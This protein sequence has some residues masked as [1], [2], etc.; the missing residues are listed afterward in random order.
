MEL[1]ELIKNSGDF[2]L[3]EIAEKL[4]S[5]NIKCLSC[6]KEFHQED[7]RC[8]QHRHGIFVKGYDDQYDNPQKQWVYFTCSFCMHDSK[9]NQLVTVIVLES[10][11]DKTSVF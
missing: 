1:S 5:Y 3:H 8:Y 9:F 2:F 7:I 6:N 10:V 11:G 4:T